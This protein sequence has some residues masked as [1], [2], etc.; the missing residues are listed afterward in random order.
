MPGDQFNYMKEILA[1]PS[2]VG[3]EAAMTRGVFGP[4]FEQY[5]RDLGWAVHTFAGNAGV[6]LDTCPDG[7]ADML[8]VMVVGHADK[9][10]MQVRDIAADGK[11]YVDTDSFL[12]LTLIG[13]PVSLFCRS[14][15]PAGSFKRIDGGTIEAIGAIH[16]ASAALREGRTGIKKDDVYLELQLH[17]E[18]RKKQAQDLGVRVG[19]PIL[20]DRPIQR[21]VGEHSFTGAYLDNGLGCFVAAELARLVSARQ[22][23]LRNVRL[24]AAMASHEEIGRFG[25]RVL[26]SVFRPD[27]LIAV[28]VNHDYNAA[29]KSSSKHYP[30]LAMGEGFSITNGS[31]ASPLLNQMLGDVA[32]SQG[33]PV[34]QDV[35][36]RDTGTDAM[37]AV[38]AGVDCA[39][40][41]I[42][43]P[44]R[45]MHTISET[46]HTGD[47]LAA[48]HA[49]HALLE[50][51]ETE[52][53]DKSY[54]KQNHP[55]LDNYE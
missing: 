4:I 10:R 9:I 52:A 30:Q 36:G 40:T 25:S 23:P 49:L 14:T 32:D 21:G 5:E 18:D 34:Q 15:S 44:I 37:A 8:N 16:F 53:I 22:A 29:P 11:I 27:V 48:L 33:I 24:L 20:L 13:C 55:R 41:S 31:I 26:A 12:P 45:N 2:P 51:M 6:V 1:S 38:L 47:V 42:G 7:G 50:N 46:G 19:D 35:R 43:F 3:F 39:A 17:G 28:D 54:F